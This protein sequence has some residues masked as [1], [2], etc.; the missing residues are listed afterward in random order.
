MT[1]DDPTATEHVVWRN[2]NTRVFLTATGALGIDINGH[3]IVKTPEQWH[4][5]A[6]LKGIY[7]TVSNPS[8]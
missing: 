3:V 7:G 4:T 8:R 5:L 2:Y 6:A 1:E